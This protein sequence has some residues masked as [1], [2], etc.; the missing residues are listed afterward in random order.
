MKYYVWSG[1]LRGK[2]VEARRPSSAVDKAVREVV[3]QE[4]SCVLG[5]A[6][7]VSKKPRGQDPSDVFY[8]PPYEAVFPDLFDGTL[9]I[10]VVPVE[11]M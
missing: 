5:P 11:E 7:R 10:R 9:D 1:S 6:I 2:P 8:V 3:A 4:S